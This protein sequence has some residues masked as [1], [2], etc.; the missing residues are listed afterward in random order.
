MRLA[1]RLLAWERIF[2]HRHSFQLM[3]RLWCYRRWLRSPER[4]RQLAYRAELK[5]MIRERRDQQTHARITR[6]FLKRN[7]KQ[8]V[9]N[10]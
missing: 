7:G 8:N 10:N 4:A 1:D 5:R 9:R 2:N 3:Y 6:D